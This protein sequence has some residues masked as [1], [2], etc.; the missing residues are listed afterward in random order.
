MRLFDVGS[1][2]DRA[3][4]VSAVLVSGVLC[5]APARADGS[6]QLGLSLHFSGTGA[7]Y[8]LV[9]DT[10]VDAGTFVV[11]GLPPG[12]TVNKVYFYCDAVASAPSIT[13][14]TLNGQAIVPTWIGTMDASVPNARFH[15][16]RADV[17][18]LFTGE[19]SYTWS[20]QSGGTNR[21]ACLALFGFNPGDTEMWEIQVR[22][23]AHGGVTADGV[24]ADWPNPVVF[25]AFLAR[26]AWPPDADVTWVIAGGDPGLQEELLIN[27]TSIAGTD[28][29][30]QGLEVLEYSI[31]DFIGPSTG[32][33]QANC[34]ELTDAIVWMIG[35]SR[36][37]VCQQCP[38]PFCQADA[39]SG[40]ACPCGN[41]G[42]LGSGCATSASGG[43]I[44]YPRGTVNP[45][46]LALEAHGLVPN[47][48]TVLFQGDATIPAVAFGDGLLCIG[49]RLQRIFTNVA[50]GGGFILMPGPGDPSLSA[51]S[52]TVGDPLVPGA[53]R[54]YQMY[55]RD[56][57]PGFCTPDTFNASS[58]LRIP[59]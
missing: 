2:V 12:V 59:W 57:N 16:Y 22:D 45:D 9:P 37:K 34:R 40:L 3:I 44:V 43:A 24:E 7:G 54:W 55:Y 25:D 21:G 15:A 17:T 19:G 36:V 29:A 51:R 33:I 6:G 20:T 27:S 42:T 49:G 50:D 47:A 38:T 5:N 31:S 28:P 8:A 30:T 4:L 53:V 13:S 18:A 46:T 41:T 58:G 26:P 11:A 39:S 23:G 10:N 56:E 32:S 52:T 14:A 1:G 48:L 35:I